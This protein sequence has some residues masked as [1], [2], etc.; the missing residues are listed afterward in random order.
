MS[1]WTVARSVVQRPSPSGDGFLLLGARF[2]LLHTAEPL[3]AWQRLSAEDVATLVKSGFLVPPSPALIASAPS[4]SP[5]PATAGPLILLVSAEPS[6][7]EPLA[8]ALAFRE[9]GSEV[10]LITSPR[11][12]PALP[13]RPLVL[14][15]ED[16]E[17]GSPMEASAPWLEAARVVWCGE[18]L[19]GTHVGPLLE[20]PADARDYTEATQG[21]ASMGELRGMGFGAQ[22]PL[23]LMS[24]VARAPQAVARA[25]LQVAQAPRGSCFLL[26][27]ER[28]VRL[29]TSLRE[30]PLAPDSLF[31]SQRWSKGIFNGLTV[32]PFADTAAGFIASCLTP[33][34][35][36]GFLEGNF[37]KGRTRED[38]E[39]IARGEAIERFAAWQAHHV[40][41]PPG[42]APQRTYGLLD[43]HPDQAGCLRCREQGLPRVP[44][45]PVW[46]EVHRVWA[47]VPECLVPFP[48]RAP[49]PAL[50]FGAS[51]T[52]GLAAFP[53][54]EGAVLR[55]TL[56]TLE[57]HNFYPSF[58]HQRPGVLLTPEM[59]PEG[60]WARE[61]YAHLAGL[62]L[63]CWWL[64]YPDAFAAPVL[65][66]FVLDPQGGHLSRG[67]GSGPRLA[68][69]AE[70]ALLEALLTRVQHQFVAENGASADDDA[71]ADWQ[72]EEVVQPLVRYLEAQPLA[73]TPPREFD[74]EQALLAHL[75][76]V[77]ADQRLPLLVA[78]LPCPV[79]EWS[80]V[81]VLIPGLT[82]HQR[83]SD[84]A[85]GSRLWGAT[86]RHGVPT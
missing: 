58:L 64:H 75:L 82:T 17:P 41:P 52:C 68:I 4:A 1:Q 20:T 3:E 81:R 46:D 66:A 29:W 48:Y 86:F 44:M 14:L 65:H 9:L 37:G 21:W 61:L 39:R 26:E 47:E 62:G 70:K 76:S 16:L 25:V 72:R 51:D 35:G 42:G 71:Y 13:V 23:G 83:A 54:R 31:A 77:L 50:Q 55:G 15:M 74:S 49:S 73:S 43:F 59:L 53:S 22:W 7:P 79:L 28:Q 12:L 57:R 40:P 45:R 69:A 63:R 30:Q 38:A 60:C 10:Q 5:L 2:E 36:I 27:Q 34:G 33:S 84:S 11:Q 19:E 67:S 85:G 32:E 56:E 24:H 18:C 78:E 80:A 6:R 8:L